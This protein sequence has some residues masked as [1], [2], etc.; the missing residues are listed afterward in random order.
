[1]LLVLNSVALMAVGT[2]GEWVVMRD[3]SADLK[4]GYLEG[5]AYSKAEQTGD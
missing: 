2:V 4:A 3:D 1:M 5:W